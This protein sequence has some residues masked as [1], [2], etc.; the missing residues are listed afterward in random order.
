MEEPVELVVLVDDDGTPI[1]SHPKATVHTTDTP[2]HLAFS[3]HVLNAAGEVLVSRRAL[4][5][6]TWPG[7]WTNAFCGHPAPG[8]DM[9]EAVRRRARDELGLELG[10]LTPIHRPLIR[11]P[12][13]N[14]RPATIPANESD[15]DSSVPATVLPTGRRRR[16]GG[17]GGRAAQYLPSDSRASTT[18]ARSDIAAADGR[19]AVS[20]SMTTSGRPAA[21]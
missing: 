5:K 15:R 17:A 6:K 10:P 7:V 9:E 16:R 12:G 1:G 21:R 14:H 19:S 20:A 2:L 8:E 4:A 13:G 18:S 3:C 11:R